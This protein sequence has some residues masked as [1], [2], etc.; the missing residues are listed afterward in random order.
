MFAS[1][2]QA[3]A[4]PARPTPNF[5]NAGGCPIGP[6]LWPV[7]RICSSYLSFLFVC[8]VVFSNHGFQ[9]RHGLLIADR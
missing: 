3:I 9:E 8:F 1:P 4:I 7:H 2:K 5:F 6:G